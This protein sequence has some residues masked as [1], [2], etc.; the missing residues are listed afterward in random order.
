MA[1]DSSLKGP[2]GETALE[3]KGRWLRYGVVGLILVAWEILPRVGAVPHLFLPPPSEALEEL[4]RNAPEFVEN[5]WVTLKEIG[6]SLVIACGGG[7]LAG[8]A[9]GS[10]LGARKSLLPVVSALFAVPLVILYP[11]F[12][13]WLGIGSGSKIAFASVYGFLPTVLGTAAGVQT[14]DRRLT[15]VAKSMGASRR[16]E[17]LWVYLPATIPTVLASLRL[18]GALVIVGVVVAEMLTSLAGVGFLLSKYR[19]QLNSPGIYAS[20]LLVLALAI[21]FDMLIQ[22]LERRWF[23]A[24]RKQRRTRNVPVSSEAL[25]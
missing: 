17:I 8:L 16:Q 5:L 11:L 21:C 25:S 9:L 4:M 14:I 7:I 19:T 12:T 15:V 6:A 24:S 23:S 3:R 22:Q 10:S 13:A 2:S 1:P 20:I 18:G